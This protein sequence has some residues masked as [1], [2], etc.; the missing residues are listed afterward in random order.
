MFYWPTA[1]IVF[2]T[3]THL[4][5]IC[6]SDLVGKG[7][8]IE[9]DPFNT[10]TEDNPTRLRALQ[11]FGLDLGRVMK[12]TKSH[13]YDEKT[14]G[15]SP[16]DDEGP[17][18]SG[19]NY[20]GIAEGGTL[21]RRTKRCR[22]RGSETE[23]RIGNA[24]TLSVNRR[25][26]VKTKLK[27]LEVLLSTAGPQE[28]LAEENSD[29]SDGGGKGRAI[30]GSGGDGS[31]L[32]LLRSHSPMDENVDVGSGVRTDAVL[33]DTS[34]SKER[35]A[36]SQKSIG[37]SSKSQLRSH[38]NPFLHPMDTPTV[39]ERSNDNDTPQR[40]SDDGG[41]GG[42]LQGGDSSPTPIE[43]TGVDLELS[44][45]DERV[46]LGKEEHQYE[47]NTP[48]DMHNDAEQWRL[49]HTA[50]RGL[51]SH[52]PCWWWVNLLPPGGANGVCIP[53]TVIVDDT[54]SPRISGNTVTRNAE[55]LPVL[56][57]VSGV[58]SSATLTRENC[59]I[60]S[61]SLFSSISGANNPGY[62]STS[63]AFAAAAAPAKGGSGGRRRALIWTFF[64]PVIPN[65]NAE[66][67]GG[68]TTG[69]P[70]RR[71]GVL[72]DDAAADD[73]GDRSNV[74]L[75]VT[76]TTSAVTLSPPTAAATVAT[77]P[78]SE[79]LGDGVVLG[80]NI[81]QQQQQLGPVNQSL[82]TPATV[83]NPAG[84]LQ[85]VAIHGNRE[86]IRAAR[87]ICECSR[88]LNGGGGGV[89][90]CT[91]RGRDW[92]GKLPLAILKIWNR[93]GDMDKTVARYE[94]E[95]KDEGKRKRSHPR[96]RVVRV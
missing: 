41:V 39:H 8:S 5:I 18:T 13:A 89:D 58:E 66:K 85:K 21:H 7:G 34:H 63:A 31:S 3:R 32:G 73:A 1:N 54:P 43:A 52:K 90:G 74:S 68:G 79:G 28:P 44:A 22:R 30:A 12:V 46:E 26:R 11:K 65:D 40:P 77:T 95:G 82:D 72:D 4:A 69:F 27:A 84:G 47:D 23:Q 51:P 24:S 17:G 83:T 20:D 60:S 38:D 16:M 87:G 71:R 35:T 61:S 9:D 56:V 6:R 78:P 59:E 10:Y 70:S 15:T 57:N 75:D 36:S 81:E 48:E 42:L 88:L 29:D 62:G 96:V 92:V 53:D 91:A 49:A 45:H 93:E 76:E 14:T 80:G 25:E 2:A 19:K 33:T 37:D 50:N 94:W 55:T 86:L 64:Q 67:P